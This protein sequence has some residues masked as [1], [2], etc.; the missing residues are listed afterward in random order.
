M[1]TRG[2]ENLGEVKICRRGLIAATAAW[3][4]LVLGGLTLLWRYSYKE[5]P[6]GEKY[7]SF[8]PTSKL[9]R[10]TDTPT[11]VTFVHPMCPCSRATLEQLGTVARSSPTQ[12][13]ILAVMLQPLNGPR[14]ANSEN[15]T[16][17][18]QLPNVSVVDDPGGA[19]AALFSSQIS[20]TCLLFDPEGRLKF[21][22]GVTQSR[23]HSG[24]NPGSRGLHQALRNVSNHCVDAAPV[25]YPVYGCSL[26]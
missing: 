12:L 6:S 10:A 22:G 9:C 13:S 2:I 14:W 20:G 26:F 21:S 17:A 24:D 15:Q 23:G 5:Q 8:P 25:S 1:N 16:L 11:L 18:R 3:L 4:L 19:E 7:V